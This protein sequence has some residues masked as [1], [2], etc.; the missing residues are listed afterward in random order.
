MAK[1]ISRTVHPANA[2]VSKFIG[3][4]S[5]SSGTIGRLLRQGLRLSLFAES[6]TFQLLQYPD[7]FA[8]K[9]KRFAIRDG[10]KKLPGLFSKRLTPKRIKPLNALAGGHNFN[11]YTFAR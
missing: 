5:E 2:S 6:S 8:P 9:S 11:L 3:N 4:R 10:P 7:A 1:A